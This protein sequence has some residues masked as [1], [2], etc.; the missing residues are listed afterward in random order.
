MPLPHARNLWQSCSN[1]SH[2]GGCCS[3]GC[4]SC[5][6]DPT[7]TEWSS[8]NEH[9]SEFNLFP[10]LFLQNNWWHQYTNSLAW[11]G[12]SVFNDGFNHPANR[13]PTFTRENSSNTDTTEVA[14]PHFLWT[15]FLL[16]SAYWLK[17]CQAFI[18]EKSQQMLRRQTLMWYFMTSSE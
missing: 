3:N 12:Y 13:F 6:M 7:Q 17:L 5:G 11:K 15:V 10:R 4:C 16:F 14:R 8:Q 9:S 2:S 18:Y 1:G